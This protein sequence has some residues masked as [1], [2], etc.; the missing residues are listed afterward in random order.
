[1]E[2]E[3]FEFK[4]EK[5]LNLHDNVKNIKKFKEKITKKQEN[6]EEN[7]NFK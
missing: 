2:D 6:E 4:N 5:K 3:D 1:M 7:E